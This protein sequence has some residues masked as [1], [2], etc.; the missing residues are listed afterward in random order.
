ML[1]SSLPFISKVCR[2]SA[3]IIIVQSIL[4]RWC[5]GK[6]GKGKAAISEMAA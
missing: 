6:I 3:R 2:K 4:M 5:G 1:P